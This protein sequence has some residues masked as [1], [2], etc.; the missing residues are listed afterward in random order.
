MSQEEETITHRD[1]ISE[2]GI[3]IKDLPKEIQTQIKNFDKKLKRYESIEDDSEADKLFSELTQDDINISD[4][5]QN[6][7]EDI[8]IDDEEEIDYSDEDDSKP[9]KNEPAPQQPTTNQQTPKKDT[10]QMIRE[11]LQNNAISVDKLIEILGQ[12][13]DY[14]EH[15]IGSLKLKKQ[16]L[17]PFYVLF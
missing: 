1:L 14:P 3:N 10:E 9:D 4:N 8:T 6:W 12:E 15:R 16:Y 5:I 13:P 7:H 11:N 2:L 17:K